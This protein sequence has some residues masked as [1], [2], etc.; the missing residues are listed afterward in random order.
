MDARTIT[1]QIK[2]HAQRL[3]FALV[4]ITSADP[5]PHMNVYQRWLD[6]G[7][8]GEMGYLARPDAVERR[9]NSHKILPECKSILVLAVPYS[10]P[11]IAEKPDNGQ[12]YGRVAAYAWGDDY[13]EV[14][15]ERLQ[16]LVAFIEEL[17]GHP[18]P[19][20]WH[21]DSGPL[22]ERE[23]AQRA[24]LGWI[25]KNTML[26]NPGRGSYFLL[27]EILLGIQLE[28]DAPIVTDH[29]GT[30]TRCIEACPTKC[31]LPDRTLDASRCISYLTI[32]LKGPIEHELRP[33]MQD[34]VFGCDICQVV[35][36]WNERF[37]HSHGDPAFAPR[38]QKAWVDLEA[39]LQINA[40]QFNEKLKGSPVRRAKRRGYLRNLAI[41]ASNA[42]LKSSLPALARVL[43]GEKEP[44]A[45]G[46]AAWA[47]GQIGGE[48]AISVLGMAEAREK[49]S[50]VLAEIKAALKTN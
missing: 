38:A 5:A 12:A 44:L 2:T 39:E 15:K 20:R 3:G 34:W 41:A 16:A 35:C 18:V 48:E 40:Q 17:V 50:W 21:T 46:H 28:P 27:A 6:T 37:A 24:G 19:N 23:L 4:G 30:C 13:H 45:R 11:S 31:I 33:L 36:P 9:S 1:R 26:I 43:L 29:C 7:R 49:D 14:L 10:N 47:L 8:H 32:E 25:G 22:L 42:A